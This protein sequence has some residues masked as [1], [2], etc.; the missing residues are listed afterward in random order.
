MH[1]GLTEL[2]ESGQ[3]SLKAQ[4]A[5]CTESSVESSKKCADFALK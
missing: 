1:S 2:V 5:V 4:K 3:A